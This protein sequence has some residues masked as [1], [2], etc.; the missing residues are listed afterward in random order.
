MT[1]CFRSL[2]KEPEHFDSPE[3]NHLFTLQQ[4]EEFRWFRCKDGS[5]RVENAA[6]E[7]VAEIDGDHLKSSNHL[8]VVVH[9][10]SEK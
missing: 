7:T 5:F 10:E 1:A 8:Y 4:Q 6:A 2:P 3:S 9:L